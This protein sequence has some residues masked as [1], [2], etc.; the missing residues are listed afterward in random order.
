MQTGQEIWD[1][2]KEMCY[3]G[4]LFRISELM[5]EI[6]SIKQGNLSVGAYFTQIKG[7]CEQLNTFKPIPSC[8]CEVKCKC[9]LIPIIKKYIENDYVI[10]FLMGLND[11][12]SIVKTQIMLM[13]PLPSINKVFSLLVQKERQNAILPGDS[14]LIAN[15]SNDNIDNKFRTRGKGFHGQTG[16]RQPSQSRP[17]SNPRGGRGTKICTYCH[18]QGHTI[19]VCYRKHGFPPNYFTNMNNIN[20]YMVQEPIEDEQFTN[21]LT[22]SSTKEHNE[23]ALLGLTQEQQKSLVSLL[24]RS[25]PQHHSANQIVTASIL[26]NTKTSGNTNTCSTIWQS[27]PWIL[28]MGATD[29]GPFCVPSTHGHKYFLTIVDDHTRFTWLL[30]MRTKAEGIQHQTSCVESPQQNGIAERKHQHILTI[31][32]SI[33]FQS[34][35]PICF[36]NY[37]IAHS[38]HLINRQPTKYLSNK[39][40]FEVLYKTLPDLT[41]LRTFGSLCY[42]STL[43]AKRHKLVPW[44]RRCVFLGYRQGTKGHSEPHTSPQNDSAESNDNFDSI[45]SY[46]IDLNELVPHQSH[47][48]H[49]NNDSFPNTA[50]RSPSPVNNPDPPTRQSTRITRPPSYLQDYHYS[51]ASSSLPSPSPKIKYPIQQFLSYEPL[52]QSHRHYSLAISSIT[53]PTSYK[54]VILHKPWQQAI[55]S[56]LAAL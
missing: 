46:D 15:I 21:K 34:N 54:D 13:D 30:F 50:A 53:T 3:Q 17:Q 48:P 7:L 47:I 11:Q 56:E 23:G 43:A 37:A 12:F 28:D 32:R 51:L 55:A 4:D 39:S 40:P 41:H 33:L 5:G 14:K 25:N 29:H 9:T 45:F 42:A 44:S 27:D 49:N 36:W 22:D 18:K 10:C 31:A 38:I 2:L 26:H 52:S 8:L 16:G 24:E 19:D 20:S 1:N 6:Y 35:L